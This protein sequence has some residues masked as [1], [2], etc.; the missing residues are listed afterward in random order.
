MLLDQSLLALLELLDAA[1]PDTER[2]L[3]GPVVVVAAVELVEPPGDLLLLLDETPLEPLDLLLPL[4]SLALEVLAGGIDDLL[5]LEGG[6]FQPGLGGLLSVFHDA[7]AL[8]G[9]IPDLPGREVALDQHAPEQ[10][11]GR[12]N[13]QGHDDQD[14]YGRVQDT[15]LPSDIRVVS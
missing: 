6:L 12:E 5:G 7:A 2:L 9:G 4:P 3:L 11:H 10:R 1:L 14:E 8:G 15:H 13:D